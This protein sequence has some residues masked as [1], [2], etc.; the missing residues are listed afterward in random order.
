MYRVKKLEKLYAASTDLI[1]S[2]RPC[3]IGVLILSQTS[4]ST[5]EYP[6]KLFV[7]EACH[8]HE[9]ILH[10]LIQIFSENPQ[11]YVSNYP[12]FLTITPHLLHTY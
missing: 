11:K 4:C 9:F 2:G 6:S 5:V 3:S 10:T 12:S 1:I 8:T 7:T